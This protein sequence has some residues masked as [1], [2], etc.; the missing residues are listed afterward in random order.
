MADM[1]M[2][3]EERK[4]F[5][6]PK[7]MQAPS[8]PYGLRISLGPEELEK[9]GVTEAPE[10]DKEMEFSV[11]AMVVEVEKEDVE[12]EEKKFKVELQI[13]EMELEKEESSETF[14]GV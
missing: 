14:G 10:L 6:T 3:V 5:S 9:L 7:S 11:R 4:D 2:S 12:G 8:Y 13:K 1:K